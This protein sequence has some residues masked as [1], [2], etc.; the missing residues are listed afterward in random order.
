MRKQHEELL[1]EVV[2]FVGSISAVIDDVTVRI[3]HTNR[4]RGVSTPQLSESKSSDMIESKKVELLC[5]AVWVGH[6]TILRYYTVRLSE[7]RI[8][9]T[10]CA[11]TTSKSQADVLRV[12][13]GRKRE[14]KA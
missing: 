14:L 9:E 6:R 5:P 2:G 7:D 10:T 1:E 3:A 13:N 11:R 12:N 4:L 8:G